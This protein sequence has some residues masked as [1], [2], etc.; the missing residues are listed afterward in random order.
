MESDP[1]VLQAA[2]G[3]SWLFAAVVQANVERSASKEAQRGLRAAAPDQLPPG[4]A[5]APPAW[6]LNRLHQT[7]VQ[8]WMPERRPPRPG[9]QRQLA[10]APDRQM[11]PLRSAR[12]WRLRMRR[13]LA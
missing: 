12:P 6:A 13:A 8:L 7:H 1:H 4:T 9:E 3:A 10:A 2:V 11:P 5:P